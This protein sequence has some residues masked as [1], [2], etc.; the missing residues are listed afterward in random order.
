M[1]GILLT[2]TEPRVDSIA[3]RGTEFKSVEVGNVTLTHHRL[4]IQTLDNDE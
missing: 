3:H 4:P 1:C 2:V